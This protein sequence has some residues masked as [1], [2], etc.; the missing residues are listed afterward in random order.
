MRVEVLALRSDVLGQRQPDTI[1]SMQNLA[2]TWYKQQRHSEAMAMMEDCFQ[3]FG[4][5]LGAN[6]PWTQRCLNILKRWKAR[7]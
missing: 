3:L 7:A 1:W 4:E 2:I 5:I 6:H